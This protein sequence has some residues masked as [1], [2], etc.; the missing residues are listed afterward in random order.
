MEWLV[1]VLVIGKKET[2][3]TISEITRGGMGIT[4]PSIAAATTSLENTDFLDMCKTKITEAREYTM[5]Y[6][7][8]N[9]YAYL[10]SETNF[11]IFEIPMEGKEFLKK[12]Y[13]KNV[14]VRAFK[15]WDKN[16]CRV[17]IGTMDEMKTFTNAISEIFV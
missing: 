8:E 17:S 12:I 10:P 7:T 16:W 6:L 9:K 5:A 3:D 11:I 14:A 13:E 2:L 4:G 1:Y 15:F